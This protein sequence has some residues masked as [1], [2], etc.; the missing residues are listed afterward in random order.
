MKPKKD[1]TTG[2]IRKH[3]VFL[4]APMLVAMFMHN[5][6]T[7][8]DTFFVGR[9]GPEAI[10]AV[11]AS[12]P[13]FF[14]IIALNSGMGIGVSSF[15]A[16][17]IGAIRALRRPYQPSNFEKV[18]VIA[19]NG[20]LIAAVLSVLTLAIGF[21]TIK[22]LVSFLGVS[23]TVAAFMKDYLSVIYLGSGAFFL[24]NV[25]NAMLQGEGDAKT[26]MKALVI[27][28]LANI[29]LDP[30]F[31]FGYG[32]FPQ[33]GVKGAAIA[34]IISQSIGML[35]SYSHLFSGKAL[36][37][38][39]FKK[40]VY[41]NEIVRG[42]LAVSI[43][44]TASQGMLAVGIFF[45]NKIVA[46]FGSLALAGMGVAFRLESVA[47]LPAFAVGLATLSVIGQNIGARQYG[48]ARLASIFSSVSAFMFMEA[49]GIIL[50]LA[51]PLLLSI[52]TKDA[53]VIAYGRQYFSIVALAYGFLGLRLIAASSFQG[54]GKA[55]QV[56]AITS[57]AFGLMIALAYAL[58]FP[59]QLGLKGVWLG[60][61]TAHLVAGIA[62]LLW[63]QNT[64][65]NAEMTHFQNSSSL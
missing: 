63:F 45:L 21:F 44:T 62:A 47:V 8:V 23:A 15:V 26:P 52:F 24:A 30:L 29:I 19:E 31:I 6:F 57:F 13:I 9:L 4:A 1:L 25:A 41:S 58:A 65:K 54:L 61:M 35:Y 51:S 40:L 48:R 18:N 49:V 56:L 37:R 2:S 33:L 43:P 50:L 64:L 42:I 28:N 38:L 16:R 39:R 59:L 14:I 36:V 11:A 20:L 10:A 22:P 7:L 5:L 34:T 17:S 3:I 55:W 60:I 53:A 27:A 46:S 32:P 12:F